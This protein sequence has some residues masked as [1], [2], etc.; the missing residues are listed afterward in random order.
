MNVLNFISPHSGWE[1]LQDCWDAMVVQ[2]KND[3]PLTVGDVVAYL[4]S[5]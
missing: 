5:D 4:V 3:E 1:G 2:S